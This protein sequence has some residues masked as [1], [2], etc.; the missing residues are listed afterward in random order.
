LIIIFSCVISTIC[1]S[2]KQ[3]HYVNQNTQLS[4]Y[5]L[6]LANCPTLANI[7]WNI[8]QK[9]NKTI[10]WI[11]VN[12]I[13]SSWFFGLNTKNLTILKDLFSNNDKILYWRFEVIYSFQ[14]DIINSTFDI[15]LNQSPKNGYCSINPPNGT[16]MTLF[17][18]TCSDWFDQDEIKDYTIY[19]SYYFF[20][21]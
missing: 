12:Q 1:S 15:E 18:I 19:S 8:Y 21:F 10:Q 7:T 9:S 5:S 16:I 14:S 2:N 20:S 17:K 11:P 4:L 3:F 6:C 13:E